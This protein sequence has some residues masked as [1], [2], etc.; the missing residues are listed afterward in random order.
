M[1]VSLHA[2]VHSMF[3]VFKFSFKGLQR[4]NIKNI[5]FDIF[6]FNILRMF[7]PSKMQKTF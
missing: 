6:Y 2:A 1:F 5:W 4:N 3:E 7:Q